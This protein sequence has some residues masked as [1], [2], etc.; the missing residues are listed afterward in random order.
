MFNR[1]WGIRDNPSDSTSYRT[2]MKKAYISPM[3][4]IVTM[5]EQ[6]PLCGSKLP[7][8]IPMPGLIKEQP[9]ME[10]DLLDFDIMNNPDFNF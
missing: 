5:D 2:K 7:A 10:E 3:L 8:E 1:V 6:L 9:D 4:D